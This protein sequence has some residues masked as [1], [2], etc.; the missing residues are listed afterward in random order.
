MS[1]DEVAYVPMLIEF[2]VF[3]PLVF[4][5]YV[6]SL[7]ALPEIVKDGMEAAHP[8]GSMDGWTDGGRMDRW[9]GGQAHG[10]PTDGLRERGG[11]RDRSRG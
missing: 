3:S 11:G 5:V 9:M 1:P 8:D 6:Y 10:G 7:P 4:T 2:C